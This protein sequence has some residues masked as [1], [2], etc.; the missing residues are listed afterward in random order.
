MA[1]LGFETFMGFI[2]RFEAGFFEGRGWHSSS[3]DLEKITLPLNISGIIDGNL[4]R[5]MTTN[6]GPGQFQ[7]WWQA[8]HHVGV[9]SKA[10]N[11]EDSCWH[12]VD[13]KKH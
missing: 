6:F 10:Q 4:A 2:T 3:S 1:F 7:D 5:I 12:Q 11:A 9:R 8:R 13:Q